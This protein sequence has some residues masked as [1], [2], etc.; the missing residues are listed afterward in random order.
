MPQYTAPLEDIQFILHDCLNITNHYENIGYQDA[1]DESLVNAILE[2]AAKFAGEVLSPINYSGDQQGCKIENG[3]V[4]TPEG[5]VEAYQQYCEAEWSALA[6]PTQYGG[7]GLPHSL[8]VVT[9]EMNAAANASWSMYPG[10]THGAISALL[11]HGTDELKQQYL[12]NLITGEWTGTMCLTESH[13]GSDLGLLKTRA[14]PQED[15]SYAITGTKIF[16][17]AGEHNMSQNIIHLVLARLPDAPEGSAGISLFLVPKILDTN[18]SSTLTDNQVTC[19]AIEHK[20]GINGS[21]TCVINFENSKGFLLGQPNK[22]LACMF[23]MMNVARLATSVQG[24]AIAELSR[25]A[26]LEYAKDRLQM[27]SLS[28]IKAPEK[29]ADPIIVHP[30]VKRMLFTQKSLVEGSRGL[31][32]YV[33]S[34]V[35]KVE[36]HHDSDGKFEQ[37]L[38][39]LTPICK[40]FMS[41]IGF[42]STNHAVQ[43]LGG[44]GYISEWELEQQVRDSRIA[45]I[46]E[47]TNGIQALDLLG[48]KVLRDKGAALADWVSEVKTQ[49]LKSSE[50]NSELARQLAHYCDEWLGLAQQIGQ[51]ASE[52]MDEVGAAAFDFLMYSG[53]LS[54]A[55][56]LLQQAEIV[57][58]TNR[59]EAFKQAKQQTM[60]FY[61][62]RILP[63]V[64]THKALILSGNDT[65][66]CCEFEI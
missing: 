43:V 54:V 30:D 66:Q 65:L 32:Y 22:G 39:L 20:M 24:Y 34:L 31:A 49:A 27:R 62:A 53:Y 1:A 63:R 3:V 13:C 25:Q 41:E 9:S 46:Y 44:H 47:G 10:L 50:T 18:A 23:T 36:T 58:T 40:A 55:H 57:K 8:S 52:D 56:I 19:S 11:H 26:S 7:Q 28:G 37:R 45:M 42:E 38:S 35:D 60:T 15:D 5:Y 59:S 2:E 21:A 51:K 48:R 4:V 29:P 6:F 33:A 14:I 64:K 12:P 16:I 61:F 17:S